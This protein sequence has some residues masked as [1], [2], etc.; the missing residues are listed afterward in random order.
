[1]IADRDIA[2]Q[3]LDELFDVSGRLDWS[4]AT[5]QDHCPES[6]LILYRRAIGQV[7]GEMWD[8]VFRPILAA[9][10]DLTPPGLLK[11]DA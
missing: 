10:P 7:M 5:V 6:E 4:V 8:E 11:T 2:K 3:I 1:M 9:H